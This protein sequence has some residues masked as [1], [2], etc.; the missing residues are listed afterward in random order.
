MQYVP[1]LQPSAHCTIGHPVIG[2]VSSRTR[3]TCVCEAV[4]AGHISVLKLNK[5]NQMP[6]IV[7]RFLWWLDCFIEF[8]E[9]MNVV[10]IYCVH[11][12]NY[13]Y[14]ICIDLVRIVCRCRCLSA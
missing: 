2:A 6:S 3:H 10:I 8:A 7:L 4:K 9:Y 1:T 12:V 11:C 14:L 13:L 5:S